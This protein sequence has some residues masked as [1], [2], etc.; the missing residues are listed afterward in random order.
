VLI[1]FALGGV[2][3]P[4]MMGFGFDRTGSYGTILAVFV[5]STLAGAVL[6]SRLGP[7]RT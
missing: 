6:M 3:G 5:F 7:Y 2:V 1:G 4:L